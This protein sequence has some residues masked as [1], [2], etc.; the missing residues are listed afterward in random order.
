[1]KTLFYLLLAMVSFAVAGSMVYFLDPKALDVAGFGIF[2]SALLI[3]S[4][5]LFLLLR[6]SVFQAGLLTFLFL[7]FLLLQ[8]L[9]LFRFWIG[10]ILVI[11]VIV[12]EQYASSS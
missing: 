5:N 12:I 11:L 9:H 2:Y 4:F 3:G 6:L 7:S 10:A 8:Q 1:M